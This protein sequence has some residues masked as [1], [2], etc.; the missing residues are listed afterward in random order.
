MKKVMFVQLMSVVFLCLAVVFCSAQTV[1]DVDAEIL[2]QQSLSVGITK[3]QGD[4][5]VGNQSKVS[6]G[7]L[8][9]DNGIFTTNVYY[10]VDVGVA[11]NT[12][13]WTIKHEKVGNGVQKEGGTETLNDNIKVTFV[14][15]NA[16][17][18]EDDL[19]I[20]SLTNSH[21]QTYTK[22]EL[23]NGWLRIYY[24][25]AGDSNATAGYSPIG[26]DKPFG[27]YSGQVK[28]TLTD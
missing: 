8:T 27:K 11:N 6:F 10:Y 4:S 17:E 16:D 28:L 18:S 23:P 25:I 12:G 3:V 2:E 20:W 24:A 13:S 14:R 1:I 5:H 15:K 22:T 7:Q 26:L 9:Y 19:D 21:N